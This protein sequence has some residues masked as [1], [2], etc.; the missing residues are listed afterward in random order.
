MTRN[1]IGFVGKLCAKKIE[2][3]KLSCPFAWFS[4]GKYCDDFWTGLVLVES[5]KWNSVTSWQWWDESNTTSS[6]NGTVYYELF[7]ISIH[8]SVR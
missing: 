7:I 3:S 2:A 5:S 1:K 8:E 6:K 4:S